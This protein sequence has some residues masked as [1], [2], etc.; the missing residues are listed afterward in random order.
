MP[1][2]LLHR[3]TLNFFFKP[4][5]SRPVWVSAPWICGCSVIFWLTF[6]WKRCRKTTLSVAKAEAFAPPWASAWVSHNSSSAKSQ[7]TKLRLKIWK[8][9]ILCHFVPLKQKNKTLKDHFPMTGPHPLSSG[10]PQLPFLPSPI[11]KVKD[12]IDP[13]NPPCQG[14]LGTAKQKQ[15]ALRVATRPTS[16]GLPIV[17]GSL[18]RTVDVLPGFSQPWLNQI[19]NSVFIDP[20]VAWQRGQWRC[21]IQ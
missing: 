10:M 9:N 11:A 6:A 2:N 20:D 17:R 18:L 7:V 1:A 3:P 19:S 14:R 16:A 15:Q 4:N 13:A 8:S 21:W 12:W 5:A